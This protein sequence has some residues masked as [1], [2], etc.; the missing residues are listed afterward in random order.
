MLRYLFILLLPFSLLYSNIISFT[1]VIPSKTRTTAYNTD[2]EISVKI[3]PKAL[4]KNQSISVNL[5]QSITLSFE[6]SH[7]IYR[8]DGDFSWAGKPTNGSLQESSLFTTKD[9]YTYG[10]IYYDHN[11][12]VLKSSPDGNYKIFKE[13]KKSSVHKN[14]FIKIPPMKMKQKMPILK[15]ANLSINTK[16]TSSPAPMRSASLRTLNS[17]VNVL[18][19]YTPNYATY[20]ENDLNATIQF[21]IDYANIAMSNSGIALTYNLAHQ[22]LYSNVQSNESASI[23]SALYHISGIDPNTGYRDI[24]INKDIRRLRATYNIDLTSL[25]RLNTSIDAGGE[26]VGLGWIPNELS[27][28]D[29][30]RSSYNVSEYSD[31]VFAHESGH[32]LG[33][34]HDRVTD[35][36]NGGLYSYSCGYRLNSSQGTIM[37]YSSNVIQYFSNPDINY[38]GTL[39]GKPEGDTEA[40]DCSRT[41]E[42]TKATMAI[43]NDITEA[44]EPED[45]ISDLNI[46]GHIDPN[47][48]RDWY[49]VNLGGETTIQMSSQYSHIAF[50]ANLYDSDGF[51]MQSYSAAETTI[52]LENGTYN[53]VISN[54]DDTDGSAWSSTK[55]YSVTL[56]SNYVEP[57]VNNTTIVPIIHYLL[58]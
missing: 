26:V 42:E 16:Q 17:T 37:S 27:R 50:Q 21:S 55:N 45:T 31:E 22:A 58:F 44:N 49:Q 41:I 18:I 1:K 11:R 28:S 2:N 8:K 15:D 34:A 14:D 25:F 33:C 46:N 39:I 43:N 57:P 20:H 19:L 32:N 35:A 10:V 24:T 7:F 54:E 40:A 4:K 51:L 9:G 6:N 36:C 12:Y 47:T 5:P 56:T 13:N 29:M 53:L 30:R 48:D 3:N 23:N 52:N 38:N